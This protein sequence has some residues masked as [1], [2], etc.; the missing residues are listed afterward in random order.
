MMDC[1]TN[2]LDVAGFVYD[3]LHALNT[4][5]VLTTTIKRVRSEDYFVTFVIDVLSEDTQ[6]ETSS[7]KQENT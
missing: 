1:F 6:T 2:K 4:G 5:C 7:S 3:T